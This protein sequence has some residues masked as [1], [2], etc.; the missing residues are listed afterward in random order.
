MK[1][2][3]SSAALG[4]A[5]IFLSA[6]SD[7]TE[8]VCDSTENKNVE[9]QIPLDGADN[10]RDLGGYTTSDCKV[11]KN[12]ML[13][14]SDALSGL[15]GDDIDIL[16]NL[17]IETVVDLRTADEI[18]EAPDNLPDSV[19]WVNYPLLHDVTGGMNQI[20]F[21]KAIMSGDL[22]AEDHMISIYQNI[23]Q[24]FI[25]NLIKVFDEIEKGRPVLWHCTSGKDRAGMTTV[26]LLT[27]LGVDKESVMADYMLSNKYLAK[28]NEQKKE[29]F[30]TNYGEGAGEKFA[31]MF[32]V[33][34]SYLE[35]F[36]EKL[37]KDFGGIDNFIK[38]EIKV[39]VELLKKHY[40]Q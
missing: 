21:F 13:F 9:N 17:N 7:S 1:R 12:G 22:L 39:D 27:A 14:R 28:S 25:D 5:L 40:L 8:Q 33:D 30:D 26:L 36:Y 6:C 18:S 35:A 23:D 29:Y 11:I 38:N 31:P 32:I 34:E 16:N 19:N 10:V 20:E 4:I 2:L 24:Y 3:N 15:T 37:D